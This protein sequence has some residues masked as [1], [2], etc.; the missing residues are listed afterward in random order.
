MSSK[1][2]LI[3]SIF[4]KS[5]I[6]LNSVSVASSAASFECSEGRDLSSFVM[7][8]LKASANDEVEVFF[9]GSFLTVLLLVFVSCPVLNVLPSRTSS[10][11]ARANS[12]LVSFNSRTKRLFSPSNRLTYAAFAEAVPF[13]LVVMFSLPNPIPFPPRVLTLRDLFLNDCTFVLFRSE[14]L[15]SWFPNKAL[16][17]LCASVTLDT[18]ASNAASRGASST[19]NSSSSESSSSSLT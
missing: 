1:K 13:L 8:F 15:S 12:S 18:R 16:A 14:A 4:S 2:V 9:M 6:L 19:S 11:F 10:A 17:R 5:S 7:T 3:W